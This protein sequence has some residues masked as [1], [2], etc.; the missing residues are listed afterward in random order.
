[1]PAAGYYGEAI[2]PRLATTPEGFLIAQGARL[3]RSGWQRYRRSELQAGAGPEVIWV[4]RPPEEVR[5]STFIG[6]L[7]GKCVIDDHRDWISAENARWFCAGHVQNIR[8]G[9]PVDGDVCIIGDLFVTD[10]SL[11]R[12]IEQG[13]REL[14]VGYTYDLVTRDDGVFEMR[15]L[16]A[17]HIAVVDTGRAGHE[18]RILD[19]ALQ[20]GH[21]FR[22]PREIARLTARD[23]RFVIKEV[24]F[25]TAARRFLGKNPMEVKR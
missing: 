11:I 9:D 22:C 14:S 20:E 8:E 18:V 5:A 10:E 12:K 4:F 6:S 23:E 1:M 16:V 25:A 19:H 7:E 21:A 3:C 24:N 17:N 15:N 2:S 13:K